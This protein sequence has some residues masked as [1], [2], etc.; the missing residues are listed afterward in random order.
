MSSE[1]RGDRGTDLTDSLLRQQ[2]SLH[3][4]GSART[5]PLTCSREMSLKDTA[6]VAAI[7]AH[8]SQSPWDEKSVLTYFL[9][10]DTLFVVEEE[11]GT[12]LIGFAALLMT[13]PESD[14]LDIVVE[15]SRRGRGIG[16]KLLDTLCDQALLRGV[17][18]VFLEV[19]PSNAPARR[20]YEKLG[21]EETGIRK[22]YYTDPAED[23]ITMVRRRNIIF[24]NR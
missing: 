14:V 13:P 17:D 15:E 16:T 4:N 9:R 5:V 21:F 18:T 10:E 19:R 3:K 20:I 8:S 11:P 12:G 6:A 23:A 1:E 22:N 2:D 7:G 24:T